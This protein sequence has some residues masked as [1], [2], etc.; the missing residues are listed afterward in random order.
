VS[1]AGSDQSATAPEHGGYAG[2]ARLRWLPDPRRRRAKSWE[3]R[4]AAVEQLSAS[5][6]FVRL[7]QEII[8]AAELQAED[9]VLDIGAGTGLLALAAAPH[10]RRVSAIDISPAMC[11]YLETKL[12]DQADPNVDVLVGSAAELPLGADSVDVVLSNY[13]FHHLRETDKQRALAEVRRVLRPGGRFVFGDMMFHVGLRDSRDRKLIARFVRSML[14]RG[15][16][17]IW[18]LL[19][20]A[21]RVVSGRGEHP[22]GV[23][24]WQSALRDAGFTGVEVWPLDHEGGIAVARRAQ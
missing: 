17:G 23:A 2:R 5:P 11:R 7:R 16:A 18:R 20:N 21:V 22:A 1:L 9:R 12:G 10:V 15:P 3:N 19:K 13:C 4:V 6:G 14:R 24:W 8:A